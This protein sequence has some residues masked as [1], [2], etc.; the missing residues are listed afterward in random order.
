MHPPKLQAGNLAGLFG[1]AAVPAGP[2]SCFFA[3]CMGSDG[4]AWDAFLQGGPP[5]SYKW[6]YNPYKWPYKW[7]T[8]VITPISGV[9][10]LLITGR[11]AHLVVG[12]F[13]PFEK[14]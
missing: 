5:T 6:N 14:N 7:V 8:G 11:G 2:F 10:T 9:I 1:G 12:G 13:S 3:I 4:F